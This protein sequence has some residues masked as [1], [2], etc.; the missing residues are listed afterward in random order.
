MK[1]PKIN[2]ILEVVKNHLNKGEYYISNHAKERL[3]SRRIARTELLHVLKNG[4]NEKSKDTYDERYEAWNYAIKGKTL[5]KRLLRII[6][7]FDPEGMLIIT[8]IDLEE[9]ENKKS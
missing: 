4:W 6:V 2:H 7:S 9:N 5:E 8:V 3:K 1:N